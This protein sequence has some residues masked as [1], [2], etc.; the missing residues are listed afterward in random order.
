MTHILL[1]PL[2]GWQRKAETSKLAQGHKAEQ[3]TNA[4]SS[5]F[6]AASEVSKPP[7]NKFY[8]S[9]WFTCIVNLR[10]KRWTVKSFHNSRA[11]TT[12]HSFTFHMLKYLYVSNYLLKQ[13]WLRTVFR[14]IKINW[15]IHKQSQPLM[16]GWENA[17]IWGNQE[18]TCTIN[19]SLVQIQLTLKIF[20][21]CHYRASCDKKKQMNTP[22]TIYNP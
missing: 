13:Q 12:H 8:T 10:H 4:K 2:C 21:V 7:A 22:V 5:G 1:C 17:L 14:F 19:L 16:L 18:N 9:L 15:H 20:K 3:G 11:K 6:R